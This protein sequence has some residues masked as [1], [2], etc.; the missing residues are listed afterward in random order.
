M[1]ARVALV[2]GGIGGI[3]TAICRHLAQAG[4]RVATNYRDET[5]AKAWQAAQKADGF[6]FVLAPGDVSAGGDQHQPEFLLQRDP[7]D[8]RR[9]ACAQV[10]P[11]HPDQFD[12]R[13]ERP[14]RTGELRRIQGRYAWLL[15]LAGPG[16][17]QV[18]NYRQHGI[19]RLCADRDGEGRARGC[20]RQDRRTDSGR[21]TWRTR[22]NRLCSRL[23]RCRTTWV[24]KVYGR[25]EREAPLVV[26]QH[27]PPSPANWLQP[28][29]RLPCGIRPKLH[30]DGFRRCAA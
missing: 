9:N 24:G 19:A 6:D 28:A 23:P 15:D 17:R 30:D 29:S 25:E 4:H 21:P 18:R 2:T 27:E 10:G 26:L 8:H 5:K 20:A 3:G 16:E 1:T 11:H 12:Q 7:P 22:G 13:T 14:I